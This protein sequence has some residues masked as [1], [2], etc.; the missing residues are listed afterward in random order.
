MI[1]ADKDF[2]NAAKA[3]MNNLEIKDAVLVGHSMG[4]L[5]ALRLATDQDVLVSGLILSSTHLGF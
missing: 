4:G 5:V 1:N 3:L 2:N